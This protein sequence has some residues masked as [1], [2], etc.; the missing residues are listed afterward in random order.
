MQTKDLRTTW[1][2]CT[3]ETTAPVR[4]PVSGRFNVN[5]MRIAMDLA[6]LGMGVAALGLVMTRKDVAA[7]TLVRV[8]EPYGLPPKVIHAITPTRLLPAKTKLFLQC[9]RE[10]IRGSF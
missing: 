10:H 1:A 4:V 5:N 3:E 8:L 7:G 6:I 9:L 2:L